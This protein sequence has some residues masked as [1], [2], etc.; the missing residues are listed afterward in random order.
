[1]FR[2]ELLKILAVVMLYVVCPVQAGVWWEDG[3]LEINDGDVYDGEL[4]IIDYGSVDMF[5]GIV[6]KLETWDYSTGNIYG[7]HIDWLFTTDYSIVHIHGGT[8]DWLGAFQDSSVYLYA[9]DATYHLTGG[10]EN[11]PWLEGTYYRN[12]IPFSF[13]LYDEYSYSRLAI[14]PEPA[15]LLL[16]GLGGLLLRRRK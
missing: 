5:G 11:R 12:D 6:G 9:Y 1:M 14:V 15:T 7:G 2:K 8:L 3:H 13:T 4:F 16:L 10:L